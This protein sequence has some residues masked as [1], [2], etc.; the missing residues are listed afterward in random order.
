MTVIFI[1]QRLSQMVLTML[2]VATTV[3]V[4]FRLVPG[5]PSVMT[6]GI[7]ATPES[8]ALIREQMGLNDPLLVQYFNWLS[9][10]VRGD[11]GTA[12]TQGGIPVTE[13]IFNPLFR[14]L[15]LAGL[16]TLFGVI[17]AIPLGTL[18]AAR[19]GTW[20]D[21]VSRLASMAAFSVPSF[22]LGIILILVFSVSLG[23]LPSGGYVPF[24]T[25]AFEYFRH[26]LLP[27]L[28]VGLIM[29][30]IFMRFIRAAMIEVLKEDFIRTARAKG[31][32][33]RRVQYIHAL[34]NALISFVTVVGMYFGIL[35]G[36][37]VV[38]ETVFAW[39][40]LGWLTIQSVIG[41]SF[42][43]VQAGVLLAAAVFVVINTFVDVLYRLL[44]PR[45][46]FDASG[47]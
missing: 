41:R 15:E 5:D 19:T 28:T 29:T 9:G 10:L 18:A 11:L 2:I 34:R 33:R 22:W 39:P 7:D 37:L 31:A 27:V 12:Y 20:V 40:G 36:G 38:V 47:R 6:L 35:M 25:D 45:V 4:L 46:S 8:R 21:H 17:L 24:A 26:L 43:V 44:D 42:D 32:S 1:V 14:T 3:F 23:W 13:I 16:S 30:G